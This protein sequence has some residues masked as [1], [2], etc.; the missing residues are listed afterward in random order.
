MVI[1]NVWVFTKKSGISLCSKQY[2]TVEVDESLFSGFLSSINT[3]A[4]SEFDQKG[5][6]SIVMGNY[7]FMYEGFAGIVFTA[8]SDITDSD[9][10]LK[11]FL[12]E[13]R[14]QFFDNFSNQP[15]E[16][17]LKELA[18]SGNVELFEQFKSPLDFEV[19]IYSER[20]EKEL[21]DKKTLVEIYDNLINIFF[22]KIIAFSEVL[23]EDFATPLSKVIKDII[24]NIEALNKISIAWD[25]I[26][27]A[28]V[29]LEKIPIDELKPLLHKMLEKLI[30]EGYSLIGQK[31]VNKIISQ[32]NPTL[33]MQLDEI[34]D[35]GI[36]YNVLQ[37]L[38]KSSY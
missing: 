16:R 36:C 38:L 10:E 4:E 34:R 17:Y 9:K 27:F 13:I 14:K 24:K 6:E 19:K 11:D 20:R 37:L 32:L 35:L 8:A 25:G 29:E 28:S 15:W 1:H 31:P 22:L 30:I 12:I 2:G 33:A 5:V 18:K 7:K 3:L 26:S 23:D 21:K